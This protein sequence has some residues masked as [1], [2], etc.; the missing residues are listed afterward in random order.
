[1]YIIAQIYMYI[2]GD[3]DEDIA[4]KVREKGDENKMK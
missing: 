1:M 3:K 2:Y 4:E